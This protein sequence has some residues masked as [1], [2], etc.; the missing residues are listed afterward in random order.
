[1]KLSHSRSNTVNRESGLAAITAVG[2]GALLGVMVCDWVTDFGS[3]LVWFL[4]IFVAICIASQE[5][6]KRK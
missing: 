4:P 6:T 3:W 1:M 5:D 2:S